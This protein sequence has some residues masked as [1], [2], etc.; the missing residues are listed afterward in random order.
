MTAFFV[1]AC[2]VTLL[3]WYRVRQR[4]LLPLLMIFAFL[5]LAESRDEGSSWRRRFDLGAGVS[6]L[7]LLY[8]VSPRHPGHPP[9]A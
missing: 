1:A 5:A 6:G 8:V 7:V 9:P 4:A 3:Q 2:V